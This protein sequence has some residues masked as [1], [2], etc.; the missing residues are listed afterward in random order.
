MCEGG[1]N[2]HNP[3]KSTKINKII[4]I[5]YVKKINISQ[6]NSSN[7]CPSSWSAYSRRDRYSV[8]QIRNSESDAKFLPL[9]PA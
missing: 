7:P 2:I 8:S 9:S 5:S 4:Q 6:L 1:K 3:A